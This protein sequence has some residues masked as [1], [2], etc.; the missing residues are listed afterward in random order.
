M[1]GDNWLHASFASAAGAVV[2]AFAGAIC[3]LSS[4]APW[5][6]PLL[7]W[8]LCLAWI[9]LAEWSKRKW[10]VAARAAGG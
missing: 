10:L 4:N 8:S 3:E 1:S 5:W 9:F 6:A 2:W 7:F